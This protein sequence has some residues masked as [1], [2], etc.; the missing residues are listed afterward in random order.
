MRFSHRLDPLPEYLTARLNR[1]VAERRAAGRDVIALGVGDPDV[2]PSI[3]ARAAL[4]A[5]VQRDDV[6]RYPTNAGIAPLRQAVARFYADRFGVTIDPDREVLP[7][8]GAKEGLAHL[9]MAQLDP[10]DASLIADP[11]YPVYAGGPILAGATPVPLPLL[12]EL[13]FQ[14][15]LDAVSVADRERANLLVIGYPNNPTGAVMADDLFERLV[16]FS[17]AHDVPVC[18]DNAYS[19]ITF[20]GH[21]APSYL[22]T[23][24]A[25]ENGI[26]ILSLSKAFSLPGWRIAFAV[27]NA[28]IIANL[29][30]LKTNVDSGMFLAMQHAAIG[31]LGS[32]PAERQALSAMY[33]GRRDVVCDLLERAGVTLT[34]PGGTL[35]LWLRV[36]THETSLAFSERILGACDV[37]L[38]P[39][40]AYGTAGEGFVRL[41]LTESEERLR[42]A[43]E[44]VIGVL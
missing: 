14:P 23:P 25:R 1:L 8:L 36:P 37:V 5:L 26:E 18:H 19:E 13:A 34:R 21:V 16:A 39:G 33:Q 31:L 3:A 24:G 15:D 41:S 10:G 42:E 2:P 40:S 11:G 29:A 22:A 20:D 6:A 43:V 28:A 35:Y 32:D 7:L 44:R 12:P 38:S 4:A 9:A 30:K 27:G 17:H